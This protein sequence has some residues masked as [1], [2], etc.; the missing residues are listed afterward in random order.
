MS[1]VTCRGCGDVVASFEDPHIGTRLTDHD[2][3][4]DTH[5]R[6][7]CTHDGKCYEK[8]TQPEKRSQ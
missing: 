7:G 8:P 4:C 3:T 2:A 1:E 6:A 5:S